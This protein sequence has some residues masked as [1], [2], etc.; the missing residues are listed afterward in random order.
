M[1]ED[2]LTMLISA[3][4]TPKDCERFLKNAMKQGRPDLV[5]SIRKREIDI[6]AKAYCEKHGYDREVERA[7]VVASFAYELALP[8]TKAGKKNYAHRTWQMFKEH[9][10]IDTVER[11]VKRKDDPTGYTALLEM[12]LNEHSFETVV[13][14]YFTEFSKEAVQCSQG[15]IKEWNA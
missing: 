8:P 15:R 10:V 7:C 1:T 14:S 6:R 2:H 3:L 12:G 11:L 9:G 5:I 13:V 4:E